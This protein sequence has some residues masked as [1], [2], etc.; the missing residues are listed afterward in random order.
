MR[1]GD[2]E[3]DQAVA[4]LREAAGQGRLTLAELEERVA[5]ALAARTDDE[6]ATLVGDL[7]RPSAP[8]RHRS[9]HP[10]FGPTLAALIVLTVFLNGIPVWL[11]AMPLASGPGGCRH[12]GARLRRARYS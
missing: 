4:R 3:R 10:P 7:P 8:R 1:I 12:K 9:W 2:A 6:L 11:L 5:R